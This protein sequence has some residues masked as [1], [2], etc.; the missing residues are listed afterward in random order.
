MLKSFLLFSVLAACASAQTTLIYDDFSG[1]GSTS[2]N[3]TTPDTSLGG[4][5]WIA[6]TG[7]GTWAADGSVSS[8]GPSNAFLAFTPSAGHV[9]TLSLDANPLTVTS[10]W[11]ALGF[12]SG[13]DTGTGTGFQDTGVSPWML[14]RGDR[15]GNAVQTFIGPN[16]AGGANATG[17]TGVVN[18]KV[19]LDTTGPS[20]T[21]EWFVNNASIR[22]NTYTTN[23]TI[24]YVGFG[25]LGGITGTVDNFLL[26][27]TGVP[28]PATT[29]LTLGLATAALLARRRRPVTWDQ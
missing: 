8:S 17:A 27:A 13:D 7:P 24:N 3:G 1:S 9:Y 29:A 28:E 20:W 10:S 5:T 23:P 6:T 21:A 22:Q 15:S 16:T 26:T 2:L 18:L 19:V 4:E 25:D 14:L 11:F 12:G